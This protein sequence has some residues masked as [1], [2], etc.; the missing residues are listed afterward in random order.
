MAFDVDKFEMFRKV[1]YKETEYRV[2]D[3]IVSG[4][5]LVVK[6][7]DVKNDNYPLSTMVIPDNN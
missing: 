7:E 6:E 2:V 4:L 5:L 1:T 3:V